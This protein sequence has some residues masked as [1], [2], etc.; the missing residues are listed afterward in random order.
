MS[1]VSS[2]RREPFGSDTPPRYDGYA[3]LTLD[4]VAT[5]LSTYAD[6]AARLGGPPSS[7][8]V[9]EVGDGNLNFVYIVTGK[10]GSVCAKQALPY[11]R[12]VG[13][14]WPL[15]LSRSFYEHAALVRQDKANGNVPEIYHFD[16]EQAL[17]IMENLTPHVIWRK[18]LINRERHETAAAT[19]ADFMAETLFRTSDLALNATEKKAEMALFSG[20]T[21]LCKITEDLV[22]TDP[23][24]DH[25]LNR[26]TSPELDG[27]VAEIRA[28][29]QWKAAIQGLKF[30]FLT[31]AEALIHGDLH[32]GSVMV[33]KT[34]TGE[35]IRVIDSEFGFYG[36][37]A[38]DIGALNANLFLNAFAQDGYGDGAR[39]YQDWLFDQIDLCWARFARRFS[40]LWRTERT[41]DAYAHSLYE[42]Q[43][44]HDASEMALTSFLEQLEVDSLGFAGAKMA[45]RILGLAG[46]ADLEGIEPST[47]RAECETRALDFARLLIVERGDLK[48]MSRAIEQAQK[49]LRDG[50]GAS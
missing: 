5:R 13:D 20:N 44:H 32:T 45:R 11:V 26:W 16:A 50:A 39:F 14:S 33:A 10:D 22:F 24:F 48:S 3:P 49:I 35:D 17:I 37:M 9:R 31:R 8:D 34:D 38:F 42:D 18:A 2:P 23:Y 40:E 46:V 47:L 25:P 15:P 19:M 43:N 30:S 6:I 41:G 28:D 12:L 7:W 21:A 27:K 1:T 29:P 4:S 36:P